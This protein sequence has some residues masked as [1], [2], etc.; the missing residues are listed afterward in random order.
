MRQPLPPKKG[1]RPTWRPMAFWNWA[2][3]GNFLEFHA[4]ILPLVFSTDRPW[5]LS[6]S[7]GRWAQNLHAIP[8]HTLCLS[9]SKVSIHQKKGLYPLTAALH[10]YM[11]S[12]TWFRDPSWVLHYITETMLSCGFCWIRDPIPA[13]IVKGKSEEYNI[14]FAWGFGILISISSTKKLSFGF[15]T[16]WFGFSCIEKN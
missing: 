14:A 5:F 4:R 12:G 8:L 7:I 15:G 10:I 2:Y 13:E 9:M 11:V 16:N 3:V 1:L 6:K